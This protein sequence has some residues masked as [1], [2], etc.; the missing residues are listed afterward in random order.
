MSDIFVGLPNQINFRLTSENSIGLS[1][2]TANIYD[3]D[4]SLV[5]GSPFS[6]VFDP[7]MDSTEFILA[8]QWTP[9]AI[10][11]YRIEWNVTYTGGSQQVFVQAVEVVDPADVVFTYD[12]TTKIGKVR[13]LIPD[14]KRAVDQRIYSDADIN[15]F[16]E[17]TAFSGDSAD[18]NVYMAAALAIDA[19]ANEEAKMAVV[20]GA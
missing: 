4:D 12:K 15:A 2:V 16:L 18:G 19:I 8:F 14:T 1:A 13:L 7:A 10:G 11:S 17:L 20:R 5:V 9:A 3:S 6:A